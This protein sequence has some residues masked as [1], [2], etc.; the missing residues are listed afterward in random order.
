VTEQ[1]RWVRRL[2][3]QQSESLAGFL[4]GWARA[5]QFPSRRALLHDLGM[6]HAIRVADGDLLKLAQ[7]LDMPVTTLSGMA[8]SDTPAVPALRRIFTRTRSEAVCPACLAEQSYSRRAWSHALATACPTHGTQLIDACAH[9]GSLLHHDRLMPHLCDCGADL[10]RMQ[11]PPAASSAEVELSLLLDGQRPTNSVLPFAISESVP[12]DIDLFMFGFANHFCSTTVATPGAKPGKAPIPRRTVDARALLTPALALLEQWPQAF[13]SR[14]EALL[15]SKPTSSTASVSKRLG[16]WYGF[17]FRH[18]K[19][20]E[21]DP[22][23][24]AT[25]DCIVRLHDGRIDARTHNLQRVA[26]VE[27]EWFSV[28]EAARELRV[29]RERL[30]RG[31]DDGRIDA[32]VHDQAPGYCERFISRDE[33]DRLQEIKADHMDETAAAKHLGVPE[34]VLRVLMEAGVVQVSDPATTPPVT[35]GLVSRSRLEELAGRLLEGRAAMQAWKPRHVALRDLNLRRTTDRERLI[36]LF[37]E[38]GAGGIRPAGQD[39]TNQLGGLLFAHADIQARIA[40]RS[41]AVTLTL[42]QVSDLTAAHYD[43]VKTWAEWGLLRARREHQQQGSP[44]LVDLADLIDFL[45]T[46]LP[47]AKLASQTRLSSRGIAARFASRGIE[48]IGEAGR[49]GTLVRVV[50]LIDSTIDDGSGQGSTPSTSDTCGVA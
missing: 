24:R 46:H 43:A 9:C 22:I 20:E 18:F 40:S 8:P 39:G 25:A 2:S 29:S 28:A 23:R 19:R 4:N 3:P 30:M 14:I 31:I 42:Q 26:S 50:D 37:Q 16:P 27:K 1:I 10:R 17:L 35:T 12:A 41:V 15:R 44:W 7:A 32:S 48:T 13:T 5:N 45:S 47:L 6:S 34:S 21:Y 49:R 11:V 33:I 38:I 36:R